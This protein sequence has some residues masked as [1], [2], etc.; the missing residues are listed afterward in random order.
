MSPELLISDQADLEVCR[1]TKQS[2]CYALGMVVYEVL[3]GHVPFAPFGRYAVMRRVVDGERPQ[4]PGG[5]EGAWFTDD[6]WRLLNGCWATRPEDRPS[7]SAVLEILER[8]PGDT[9]ELALQADEDSDVEGDSWHLANNFSGAFPWF[10][11][12]RFVAPLRRIL[13]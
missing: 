6:L 5:M 9:N 10:D 11:P 3:S 12:R 13:C 2:D 1:P 4:R 8:V 7:V